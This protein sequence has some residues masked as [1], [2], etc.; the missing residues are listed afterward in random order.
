MTNYN[1]NKSIIIHFIMYE[2]FYYFYAL[3]E[4]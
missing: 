4:N 3:L 1:K 2:F